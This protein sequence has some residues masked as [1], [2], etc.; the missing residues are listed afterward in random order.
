MKDKKWEDE[1][2]QKIFEMVN[3]SISR[4]K[5]TITDLTEISKIQRFADQN[6]EE[7]SLYNMVNEVILDLDQQIK[8][9]GAKIKLEIP[10]GFKIPFSKKNLKSIVYNLISNAVKYC[11]IDRVPFILILASENENYLNFCVEDNGL[12][13]DIKDKDKIFSMFKRLHSHVEGT[14]IGLYMVKKIMDNAGGKV[15]VESKVGGGSK[16]NVFFPK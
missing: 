13:F 7:V 5:T 8:E 16:F 9:A 3:T 11:S 1:V 4:F 15:E 6:S 12:G 14:G 2:T 10:E